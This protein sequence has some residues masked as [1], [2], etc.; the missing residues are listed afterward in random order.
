[1]PCNC[2]E[3]LGIATSVSTMTKI[4]DCNFYFW[5]VSDVDWNLMILYQI[6]G[7]KAN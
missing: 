3:F 4:S 7:E 1:M 2:N 5:H 6:V